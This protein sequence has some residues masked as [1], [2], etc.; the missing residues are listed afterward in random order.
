MLMPSITEK[1]DD[2]QQSIAVLMES[3]CQQ[4]SNSISSL[5]TQQSISNITSSLSSGFSIEAG[6]ESRLTMAIADYVHSKGL[7]FSA[8]EGPYFAKVIQLARCVPASYAP[9]NR[10]QI[11]G[12]LFEL[13]Y[14]AKIKSYIT[15]LQKDAEVF[16]LAM[17]GDG[18]TV[19]QMPLL[20]IMCSG[21][22]EQCAVLD[23]VDCT[24]HMATG[25]RKMRAALP[26]SSISR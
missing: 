17:F 21:F 4:S 10:K 14:N 15:K 20:N 18:A 2:K 12:N 13:S 6:W 25:G 7:A 8:T 19:K 23:V 5:S 3:K 16:G 26:F 11:G 9:P 24:E 22:D 1:I